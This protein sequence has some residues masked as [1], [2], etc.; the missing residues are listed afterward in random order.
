MERRGRTQLIGLVLLPIFYF[1]MQLLLAPAYPG[2]SLF[3]DPASELGSDRSPVALWFNLLAVTGGLLG[4]AG[5]W[6]AWRTLRTSGGG[7]I[8]ALLLPLIMGIVAAGSIWAGIFPMPN[9][10]HPWN[11]STPAMLI[12]PVAA[13]AYAWWA[14]AFRPLRTFLLINLA[15][16][17]IVLPF[18]M[19]LVPV[20]RGA[21]GGLLQRLLA[22][23]IFASIGLIG[24]ELRKHPG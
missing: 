13:L 12:M 15:V 20:D 3:R 22:L 2:Y 8:Q 21:F 17:I 18:M 14:A 6:G 7:M 11:P 9:P 1:G 19:G 24:W 16:F 23:P 4:I 10:L 5:A